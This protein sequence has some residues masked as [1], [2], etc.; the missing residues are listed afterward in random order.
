[1]KNLIKLLLIG[2]LF[3][4]CA[5]RYIK[6]PDG[7]YEKRTEL[8]SFGHAVVSGAVSGITQGVTNYLLGSN[9]YYGYYNNYGNFVYSNSY[10]T[11]NL[12]QYSYNN[13]LYCYDYCTR[14]GL[15]HI[16]IFP[17]ADYS[18]ANRGLLQYRY[19]TTTRA[20]Y[21]KPKMRKRH[22]HSI[23]CGH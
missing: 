2:F 15:G 1:M 19:K 10:Y 16:H 4:S 20:V 13:H 7:T 14:A 11:G 17:P 18:Y 22:V 12:Y 9:G 5:I 6:Q 23:Y 8:S 21:R 3:Q